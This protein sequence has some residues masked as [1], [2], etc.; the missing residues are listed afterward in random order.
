MDTKIQKILRK[1]LYLMEYIRANNSMEKS[2]ES[3]NTNQTPVY[4]NKPSNFI[5]LGSEEIL[6][7]IELEMKSFIKANY[8]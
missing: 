8:F 3:L 2:Q 1:N 5:Y 4:K 7:M 6:I